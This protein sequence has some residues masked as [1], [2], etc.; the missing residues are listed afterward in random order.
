LGRQVYFTYSVF[1]SLRDPFFSFQDLQKEQSSK[2]D[3]KDCRD[4]ESKYQYSPCRDGV[5]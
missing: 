4:G 3:K 5:G 2:I 1:L